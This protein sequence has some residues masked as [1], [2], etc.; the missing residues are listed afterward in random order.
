VLSGISPLGTNYGGQL[1]GFS[2]KTVV[3][4]TQPPAAGLQPKTRVLVVDDSRAQRALLSSLLRK[5]GYDVVSCPD[6]IE[7]LE[8]LADP[9][10][11]VIVSDWMMPEMTGPEFCRKFRKL[12]RESYGYFILLTSKSDK[13]E[14]AHGLDAGADDFVTKPVNSHELQARIRA[15]ERILDMH[16]ELVAKNN[17]L[18]SALREIQELYDAL[19]RDLLQA[20]RLQ[21]SLVRETF[22]RFGAS[23][24]SLLLR[25]SGHIG[26][27]LVGYY[28]ISKTR[29]GLFSL[30]VSGHGVTSALI[31]A[32][33]AGLLSA[34]SPE[35]N[36]AMTRLPSGEYG[37][38]P[39]DEVAGRL[40]RVLMEEIETDHY[41]TLL[42]VDLDLKTGQATC[43]QA[44][45][46]HPAIQ[47]AD[48]SV[49]LVGEGGMPIGLLPDATYESFQITLAPGDRLLLYSDGVTECPDRKAN[50]LDE[51]G[52]I[53]I[54]HR[55]QDHREA[56]LL[57]NLVWELEIFSGSKDF[58]DDI[59]ALLL[60]Y[61]GPI[62]QIS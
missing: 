1:Q 40:N 19:D 55:S 20:K 32:R 5:W 51:D 11:S 48:G 26:G 13:D 21:K 12:K 58:P 27:D 60:E 46:P 45:H 50:L 2:Q 34:G 4:P 61:G 59:S 52:L 57:S 9:T 56:D 8:V 37:A 44:G 10:I 22:R 35:Q 7:A 18:G 3:A 41:F 24:V 15:G 39:P 47:R 16:K 23:S 42:L 29:V 17:S 49:V 28:P 25:S 54:L 31:T 62:S 30:D 14:I 53:Q 38:L 36:I 33:L 43:V 6:P